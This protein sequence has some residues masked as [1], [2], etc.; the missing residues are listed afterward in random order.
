MAHPHERGA[1]GGVRALALALAALGLN[2]L[3]SQAVEQRRRELGV[4]MALGATR[5]DI[6]RLIISRVF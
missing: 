6:M 2:A 1:A 3:M 4:R 5:Q